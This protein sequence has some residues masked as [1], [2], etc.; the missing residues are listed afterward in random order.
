MHFAG[1]LVLLYKG[2]D[3]EYR[4]LLAS[5]DTAGIDDIK[6]RPIAVGGSHDRTVCRAQQASHKRPM[7]AYFEPLQYSVAISGGLDMLIHA[8]RAHAHL[9][10]SHAFLSLDAE[11]AFNLLHRDAISDGIRDAD[12]DGLLP[13]FRAGHGHRTPL[14]SSSDPCPIGWSQQG[15]RQG[16]PLGS[17]Y[18]C[19]GLQPMLKRLQRHC[20]GVRVGAATDDIGLQGPVPELE[21]AFRW[22][23][24]HG[25]E[26]GYHLRPD[27]CVLTPPSEPAHP[28]HVDPTKLGLDFGGTTVA[29]SVRLLGASVGADDPV[30]YQ[31]VRDRTY[32]ATELCTPLAG[33][34]DERVRFLVLRYCSIARARFL[35]RVMPYGGKIRRYARDVDREH[36]KVLAGLLGVEHLRTHT[37]KAQSSLPPSLGGLGIP[38]IADT[39]PAA[40]L[41]SLAHVRPLLARHLNGHPL[42]GVV[43]HFDTMPDLAGDPLGAR[44][45]HASVK[46]KFDW[47]ADPNHAADVKPTDPSTATP[48]ME[49]PPTASG[50]VTQR[51]VMRE[52]AYAEL[53]TAKTV[54]KLRSPNNHYTTGSDRARLLSTSGK[55]AHEWLSNPPRTVRTGR[56]LPPMPGGYF[57][58][59][60][61][62]RMGV[63][64]TVDRRC[65][66]RCACNAAF[67][68]ADHAAGCHAGGWL[69]RRHEDVLTVVVEMARAAGYAV[70]RSSLKTTYPSRDKALLP[71]NGKAHYVPDAAIFDYPSPGHSLAVDVTVTHPTGTGTQPDVH[72]A[73][74]DTAH[75]GKLARLEVH[76][77]ATSAEC[78]LG[79]PHRLSFA[80]LAFETYG[81]PTRDFLNLFGELCS[82]RA[83]L[84]GFD[85][86]EEAVYRHYCRS[87]LSSALQAANARQLHHLAADAPAPPTGRGHRSG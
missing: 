36:D 81:T 77:A 60:L 8:Q 44:A 25:P 10:P 63:P 26:Y 41:A 21:R 79:A 59:A 69:Y 32:H 52:R 56:Y 64:L 38:R 29:P 75:A 84:G 78:G 51:K 82:R 30:A 40:C 28:D 6:I 50:T 73:A 74:A 67:F 65:R 55:L 15:A 49:L 70:S 80:P 85:P 54:A 34:R 61:Q 46:R 12:M 76:L 18:F 3:D 22:L 16:C 58:T 42:V 87:R 2:T 20:P 37:V 14:Y 27:K 57:R 13:Y 53:T 7:A 45:A 86:S 47:L 43:A 71:V 17:A 19:F 35:P 5:P 83:E 33:V 11:N 48:P 9:H 24:C 31:F 23:Q 72:G 66:S 62:L 68:T 39:A 4:Q 1:R